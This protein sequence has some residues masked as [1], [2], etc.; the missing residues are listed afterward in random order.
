MLI[1]E[2]RLALLPDEVKKILSPPV[3]QWPTPSADAMHR[4]LSGVPKTLDELIVET[5]E[6]EGFAHSTRMAA[7]R[8]L[9]RLVYSGRA[10]KVASPEG[11][12]KARANEP[13][14]VRAGV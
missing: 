10:R 11:V 9:S 2:E 1:S 4:S 7:Y 8:A 5:Y 12:A 14:W 13:L 6:R 3:K